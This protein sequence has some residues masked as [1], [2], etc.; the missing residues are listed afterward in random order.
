MLSIPVYHAL[1]MTSFHVQVAFPSYSL[2]TELIPLYAKKGVL[3]CH[4]SLQKLLC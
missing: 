2:C 4:K 1:A 3:K